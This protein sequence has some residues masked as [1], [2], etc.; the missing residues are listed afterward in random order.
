MNAKA[1]LA[2]LRTALIQAKLA[3]ESAKN[4]RL[5][6]EQSILTHFPTDKLEGS[7]TDA[8]HGLTVTYKVSRKVDTATLQADWEKL[9]KNAQAAFKWSA[10]VDTKTFKA[11]ADLDP[12]THST[13]CA[14]I[15]TTPN[16]PAITV[17]ESK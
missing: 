2:V 11:L 7:V 10:D 12:T 4:A 8:D 6:I 13:V 17:K 16:K 14:Y 15:T 5:E 9:P 3:E 1:S